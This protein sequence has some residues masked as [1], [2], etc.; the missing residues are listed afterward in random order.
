MTDFEDIRETLQVL[1]A[2]LDRVEERIDKIQHLA[3]EAERML[4]AGSH[5]EQ[6]THITGEL[7]PRFSALEDTFEEMARNLSDINKMAGEVWDRAA[8]SRRLA[9][10]ET[11]LMGS[12]ADPTST[13]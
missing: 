9:V 8:I 10:I 1:A 5:L 11:Q 6:A 7:E 12:T 3:I 2:R 4:N 13:I